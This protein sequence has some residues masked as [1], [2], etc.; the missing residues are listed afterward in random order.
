MNEKTLASAFAQD[1][2]IMS[3]VRHTAVAATVSMCDYINNTSRLAGN[4]DLS[5][6]KFY[7]DNRVKSSTNGKGTDIKLTLGPTPS[8][9]TEPIV[10]ASCYIPD[11][12]I[13][14]LSNDFSAAW[15]DNRGHKTLWS[16]VNGA[17]R[18]LAPSSWASDSTT[19][20]Q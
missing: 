9:L 12:S 20:V 19:T 5:P 8:H 14:A 1:S 18:S 6:K 3:K 15:L 2:E 7:I 17:V 11:P 10:L 16:T 13:P 4:S